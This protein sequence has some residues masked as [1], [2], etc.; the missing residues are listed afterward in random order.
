[1]NKSKE[2][3]S[4]ITVGGGL[5]KCCDNVLKNL[6]KQKKR[7]STSSYLGFYSID[8]TLDSSA[9]FYSKNN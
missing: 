8:M 2:M 5:V 9:L 6:K 4:I 7:P 3:G 1:M